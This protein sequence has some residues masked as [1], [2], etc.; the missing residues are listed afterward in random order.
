MSSGTVAVIVIAVIVV[1]AL[2][3]GILYDSRRRRLRQRFGPEYDRLVDERDSR[4]KA[5]AELAAR[6][7]RVRGLDIRPLNPAAQA[8]YMQ[9]WSAIQERFVDEPAQAVAAAQRLVMAVMSDR[10]YPT[11]RDDQVIADLSVDHANTLD[12]YRAATAISQQAAEGAASTESLRQAMIHYRALFRDLLGTPGEPEA[13]APTTATVPS[14]PPQRTSGPETSEP[15]AAEP[16]TPAAG[17]SESRVAEPEL[18][19]PAAAKRE[20][21]DL[22]VADL[23]VTPAGSPAAEPEESVPAEPLV[24]EPGPAE[25]VAS[26]EPARQPRIAADQAAREDEAE[27]VTADVP[28]RKT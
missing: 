26:E 15:L 23:P 12:H 13:P 4:L 2:G 21:A 25:P 22:P 14:I 20:D 1:V 9:E 10:G 16:D 24:S 7:K 19:E 6:E 3:T 8:R 18:S 28:P 17:G 11:E 5:E 27:A